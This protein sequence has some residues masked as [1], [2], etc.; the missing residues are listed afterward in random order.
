MLTRDQVDTLVNNHGFILWA[1]ERKGSEVE[2]HYMER[3]IK[4]YSQID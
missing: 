1:T 3:M 2:Y 4:W